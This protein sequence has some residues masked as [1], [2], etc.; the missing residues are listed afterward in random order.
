MRTLTTRFGRRRFLAG[1]AALAAGS[2]GLVAVGCGDD[3]VEEEVEPTAE[4]ATAEAEA[5]TAEAE[6]ATA[7]A[8]AATAE[9]EAETATRAA[10]TPTATSAAETPTPSADGPIFGGTLEITGSPVPAPIDFQFG[11]SNYAI[12]PFMGDDLLKIGNAS[13][14]ITPAVIGSW[15]QPDK[16][17]LILKVRPGVKFFD[18][19]PANGREV[20]ARDVVYMLRSITGALYPD[21]GVP[22]PRAGLY[23]GMVDPPVAIDESTVELNFSRPKSDI[24]NGMA[25]QRVCITP[26][27]LREHFGGFDS[28]F[29]GDRA[30]YFVGTGPWM[31]E[32]IDPDIEMSWV[33]NPN[34]WDD[35][36]PYIDR[37]VFHV[38]TDRS[39]QV[40]AFIAGQNPVLARSDDAQL[41][42]VRQGVPDVQVQLWE[43]TGWFHLELNTRVKPLDDPRVRRALS[44]VFD[45]PAIG[46]AIYGREKDP[47]NWRHPGAMAYPYPEA[48]PQD[49][50]STMPGQRSPTDDD[51]A[52]ARQLMEAAGYGDGF[53]LGLIAVPGLGGTIAFED[54]AAFIQEQAR[55]LLNGVEIN[56]ETTDYTG[57]L[58]RIYQPGGWE[59]ATVGGGADP[60]AVAMMSNYYHSGG[61]RGAT[62]YNNP[63][64]DSLIE[65]GTQEFDPEERANILR[66][67][68]RLALEEVPHIAT[69]IGLNTALVRPEVRNM[70]LGSGGS[71]EYAYRG[72]W[73]QV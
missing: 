54:D 23:Q 62:G 47:P 66:Q 72:A 71:P 4:A 21:A 29:G 53:S 22:F 3:D 7:E 42:I 45:K 26:E 17:T 40:P 20:E 39:T 11:P 44:V 50:L 48:I 36:K 25:E 5:A 51:I 59:M 33:R 35:P 34:Y 27:G 16:T 14:E 31:P 12:T 18:M 73:L 28:T 43:T 64:M 57:M 63:E 65:A 2:A 60:S 1:S 9:A 41:Q 8:E 61:T 58:S 49:E 68:Q 37:V 56:I 69:H 52:G 67:A 46:A 70:D 13:R 32:R 24:F 15:E 30:E 19:P 6:A 38:T 10:A 55:K